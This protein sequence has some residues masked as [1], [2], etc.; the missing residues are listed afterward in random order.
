MTIHNI[1][2]RI[3]EDKKDHIARRKNLIP[4]QEL[5]N[6][7]ADAGYCRP[8][9]GK[10]QKK[11]GN[12]Q[13]ALIAEIKK[14]SPSKGEIRADFDPPTLA[15]A[16]AEAGADCLS[17]LTDVPHFKGKD[18]YIADIKKLCPLPILRKDFI[19]D[20]YQV[21]ESKAIGA[22]A[23]LLIQAILTAGQVKNLAKIAQDLGLAVLLEVH[24]EA[25]V[26]EALKTDIQLVGINNRNLKNFEVSLETTVSLAPKLHRA[27]RTVIC[28]SGIQ[29]ASDIAE[30]K[31]RA[32]TYGFLV[33][34]S[35]M[36]ENDVETATRKLL[37]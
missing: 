24:N 17:V 1:L 10:I 21:V 31:K 14:A 4:L 35:L 27:K 29:T 3:C 6:H 28:E 37:G 25:E 23:I 20:P 36:R 11:T 18:D 34:E 15:M 5:E 32:K 9:L 13:T 8:F 7:A 19:F 22:D 12:K 33:G 2:Q 16:Y 26:K 30:I